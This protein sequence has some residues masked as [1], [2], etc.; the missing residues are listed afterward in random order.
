MKFGYFDDEN[1]EYVITSPTTPVKWINYL[2][3]LD[4]GGFIDTNGGMVLC[5]GDPALNRITKYLTQTPNSD[6]KGSS[7]YVRVTDATG[8]QFCFSPFYVPTLQPL[9]RF[10]H[11]IGL[12]YSTLISEAH[13]IRCE[14]TY[15]VPPHQPVLLQDIKVTNISEQPLTVEIIPVYEFSHF[16]ALKQLTNADWV[17]QTMT[18]Q[19]Q[20]DED[21]WLTLHQYAFMR[22]DTHRNILTANRPIT[23]FE[24]DRNVF[25]GQFGYGSWQAP[26]ALQQPQ[27]SNSECQR[28]DN[29]GALMI[30]LGTLDSAQQE[31]TIVQLCQVA[32]AEQALS[33]NRYYR[34]PAH[35]DEALA[36]QAS[37]WQQYLSTLQV[38]TPDDAMNSMLNVHNPRQCHTTRYWSRYLSLYQLGYGARGIGYRD[39]SQ[40][41]LG[42]M[43][44]MPDQCW[45]FIERL[46]SVQKSDGSAMHQFFPSTMEANMGDARE[47]PERPQFYGDDHLWM[48]QTVCQYI[49]E[50]GDF[51]VLDH[52]V[53]FYEKDAQG[54]PL[55]TADVWEHLQRAIHFTHQHIGQHGLPLLGFADWNDTVNLPTGSESIMVAC[56]YAKALQEMAE[57][58]AYANR[59]SSTPYQQWLAEVNSALN[60]QAW[61]GEW[62]CR[63]ID[64]QGHPLGSHVNPAGQIFTNAQSWPVLAG[65]APP[66]RARQA[67]AAVNDRLNTRHG[68]K[69]STPSYNGFDPH[70]GGVSTYPPGAKENGGIFLHANPWVI[71]AETI[72]GNGD[73]AYQYYQ[74]INPIN[75]QAMLDTH[76]AEPY[77]YCQNIL[78]DEHPQFGLGRNA[79]LSGTSAWTYVAATQWILGLRPQYD[80]LLL[81]PCIPADWDGFTAQRRFRGTLYDITVRNPNH[82]CHGITE[83]LVDGQAVAST[84]LPLTAAQHCQVEVTLG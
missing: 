12:S 64:E 65:L 73:R 9:D 34:E 83:L 40:D 75:K 29:I 66:E 77:V 26:A 36:N 5:K 32:T 21:G 51:S 79:W 23:S 11:H 19:A 62:Y 25:L 72:I 18:L 55:T 22:R 30:P 13:G 20:H 2:G 17:P 14:V 59:S 46:L 45:P 38:T 37:F 50:T 48:V 52:E 47:A 54:D 24:G 68:I 35:V 69:L 6:F 53:P 28:G 8:H 56:L 1:R 81:A 76:E 7:L 41:L 70:L 58:A 3:T 49:K 39:S 43:S 33:L 57:L 16:D 15:F 74:Q 67:L 82:V 10:E 60:E 63:Y 44:H 4:F 42:V 71:I 84:L 78:G 27:L 31:R 80:G 61:D